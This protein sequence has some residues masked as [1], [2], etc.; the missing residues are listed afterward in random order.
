MAP[1]RNEVSAAPAKG[2]FASH[3]LLSLPVDVLAFAVAGYIWLLLPMNLLYPVRLAVYDETLAGSW[4]GP[5]MAGA[6]AVHAAGG[7]VS[8]LVI[9]V[10]LLAVLVQAQLWVASRTL[11]APS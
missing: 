6:W 11:A 7:L 1:C 10:P 5:T 8:F 2:R 4:G 3:L 9:G